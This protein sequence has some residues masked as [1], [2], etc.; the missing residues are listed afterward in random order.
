MNGSTWLIIGAVVAEVIL[1]VIVLL[2]MSWAQ[3]NAAKRRDAKAIKTLVGRIKGAR[4]QR[5]EAIEQYLSQKCGFE[6]EM[7][8]AAKVNLLRA[9]LSL[10]QRFAAIY[11][12]RDAAAAGQFD[13]DVISVIGL[14]QEMGEITGHAG[15]DQSELEALRAENAG[16]SDELRMTMETMSRMLKD[17]SSV[18]A[19]GQAGAEAVAKMATAAAA[20]GVVA[21]AVQSDEGEGDIAVADVDDEADAAV[22]AVE[23]DDSADDIDDLFAG[24]DVD[25]VTA[26]DSA[27]EEAIVADAT[28]DIDELFEAQGE[29]DVLATLDDDLFEASATDDAAESGDSIEVEAELPATAETVDTDLSAVADLLGDLPEVAEAVEPAVGEVTESSAEDDTDLSAVADLLDEPMAAETADSDALE[30]DLSVVADLLESTDEEVEDEAP[31]APV[32]ADDIDDLIESAASVDDDVV[33]DDAA[34]SML[35]DSVFVEESSE[36]VA[37]DDAADDDELFAED[38][39]D[40]GALDEEVEPDSDDKEVTAGSTK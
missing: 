38:P 18:F 32:T 14:Y 9:E 26:S 35:A 2:G 23:S 31:V 4:G 15:G 24:G 40:L 12:S 21:D 39:F 25:D 10:L 1:I 28:D 16:L 11:R 19:E 36:I 17:Y 7:L 20:A 8:A 13:I 3:T 34:D 30:T 33:A 6:G 27:A 22:E 29:D 37:L 5:A